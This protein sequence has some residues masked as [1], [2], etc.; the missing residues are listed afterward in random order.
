MAIECDNCGYSYNDDDADRCGMCNSDLHN[1]NNPAVN[2]NPRINQQQTIE[3]VDLRPGSEITTFEPAPRRYSSP[4]NEPETAGQSDRQRYLEGRITHLERHDEKPAANFFSIASKI[5]IGI[6]IIVPYLAFFMV[7]AILSL[8]FA[9]LGY[10][11]IS[12][13]FNPIIWT[14]TIME[15]LEV[16]V[17]RRIKGTDTVPIFRGMVED[18]D[19]QEYAFWFR[20][21]IKSGNLVV[22]HNARLRGRWVTGTFM[23]QNGNDL[24]SNSAILSYY[25]NLW[26]YIFIALVII[27][28]LLGVHIYNEYP[29]VLRG[30]IG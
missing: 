5:L 29:Q 9:I 24:T 17:L 27:Y 6:L 12:Q 30:L 16:I 10:P 15:L 20:G 26:P 28:I 8:S 1:R 23:T 22:G 21:P 4:P 7:S 2:D 3:M 14:T 25:Q 19:S 18:N 11:S 13:L